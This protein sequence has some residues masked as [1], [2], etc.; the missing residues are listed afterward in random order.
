[1]DTRVMTLIAAAIT[2]ERSMTSGA[3]IARLTGAVALVAGFV[4]CVPLRG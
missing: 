3:R 1:M 2:A 4:M